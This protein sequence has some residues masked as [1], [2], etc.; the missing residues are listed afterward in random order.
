MGISTVAKNTNVKYEIRDSGLKLC[1]KPAWIFIFPLS[2]PWHIRKMS[3]KYKKKI[4]HRIS[5]G[6]MSQLWQSANIL[7]HVL[8]T[9]LT[10]N[11]CYFRSPRHTALAPVSTYPPLVAK[12]IY[13][14][15]NWSASGFWRLKRA[16]HQKPSWDRFG[17]LAYCHGFLLFAWKMPTS[18]EMA[19]KA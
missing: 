11:M 7:P 1:P 19:A 2:V 5:S 18:L 6:K 15:P 8:W 13:I 9:E 3:S 14:F 4:K 12:G 17:C 16:L 10:W